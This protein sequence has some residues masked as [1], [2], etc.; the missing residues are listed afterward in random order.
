MQLADRHPAVNRRSDLYPWRIAATGF[1]FLV[2]GLGGLAMGYLVFPVLALATPDRELRTRRCRLVVHYSFRGF[3]SMMKV[4]GVLTYEVHGAAELEHPGVEQPGVE[5]PGVEQ[6]GVEQSGVEQPGVEQ[7][8]ALVVANHPSLIDIV[9]LIAMI[10]NASCIVKSDLYRNPFTRGPVSWA[11]YV[12]N[13]APQQLLDD[14]TRQIDTG[15]TLVVFPEGTRSVPGR[16]AKFRRGAAYLWLRT[17][18]PLRLASI[19]V[20]PSTL[21]K[22]ERWYQIP[23]R[24][25]HWRLD[26]HPAEALEVANSMRRADLT[27]RELN[28]RWQ[29]YFE[30]E[31]WA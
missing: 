7:P 27:A 20:N 10:P 29:S 13:N 18:C 21:A 23:H 4:L 16:P 11:G 17:R 1:S 22:H 8:G 31:T 14:C 2:F 25:P 15:A 12:P 28:R 26:I 19:A 5:Q 30:Q 24:R 3:I 9:F 6:P